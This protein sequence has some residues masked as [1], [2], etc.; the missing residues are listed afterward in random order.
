MKELNDKELSKVFSDC[1]VP[2]IYAAPDV[3]LSKCGAAGEQT[4]AWLRGGGYRE[5]RRAS[6]VVEI[7]GESVSSTDAFFCAARACILKAVAVRVLHVREMLDGEGIHPDTWE[8]VHNMR[9][10][11]IEGFVPHD[12]AELAP[13]QR[14]ALEWFVARWVMDGKAV[15]FLHERAISLSEFSGRFK[16]RIR[17]HHK[18]LVQ[19]V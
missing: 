15:V 12:P 1:G 16:A 9:V 2:R 10:L 7:V 4:L 19:N 18:L 5:L 17:E 11:F 8:S 3:S 14:A 13:A 6:A